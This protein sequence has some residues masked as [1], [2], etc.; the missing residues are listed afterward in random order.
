MGRFLYFVPTD[1]QTISD[2]LI[3]EAGLSY[4]F[5]GA[6]DVSGV[7]LERSPFG[8]GVLFT[9]TSDASGS[10]EFGDGES[11]KTHD[12]KCLVRID[13]VVGPTQLQRPKVLPGWVLTLADGNQ[14][15]VPIATVP[16]D[17]YDPKCVLPA[18]MEYDRGEWR[19]GKVVDNYR[20]LGRVAQQWWDVW[21]P[22][23]YQALN[24]ATIEDLASNLVTW[25]TD[26]KESPRNMAIAVLSTNY[27]IGPV[28][29][30]LLG[31][32]DNQ[33]NASSVMIAC[34]D[35]QTAISRVFDHR[36]KKNTLTAVA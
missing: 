16:D 11:W 30:G 25:E 5:D 19:Q 15:T 1:S 36:L 31:I 7:L 23:C 24:A 8:S 29:A 3:A 9:R 35:G 27:R 2:E 6:A 10:I 13:G 4:A 34:V 22:P 28:E 33:D 32:F 21:W 18:V 14:W 17:N 12:G 20:N 26:I